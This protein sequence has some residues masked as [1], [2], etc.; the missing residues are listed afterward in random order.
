MKWGKAGVMLLDPNDAV[1]RADALAWKYHSSA[2]KNQCFTAPGRTGGV[3]G[4]SELKQGCLEFS[5]LSTKITFVSHGNPTGVLF[6]GSTNNASKFADLL[7]KWGL[8]SAGLLLAS[9][10]T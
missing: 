5:D 9:T 4:F 6:N 8:R 1:I 7:E 3:D 10:Q 2:P